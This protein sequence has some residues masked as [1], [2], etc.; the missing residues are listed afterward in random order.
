MI[1]VR[2][3]SAVLDRRRQRGQGDA[4]P[5]LGGL[6]LLHRGSAGKPFVSYW[7][8]ADIMK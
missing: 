8:D 2:A 3:L 4:G 5:G 6:D 1:A 7:R